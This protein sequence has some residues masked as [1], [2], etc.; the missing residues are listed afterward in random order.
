MNEGRTVFAQLLEPIHRFN[1]VYQGFNRTL[2]GQY[3]SSHKYRKQLQKGQS[4]YL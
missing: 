3:K 1:R 4:G 2:T